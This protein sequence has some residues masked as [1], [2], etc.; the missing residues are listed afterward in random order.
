MKVI[1]ITGISFRE[2]YDCITLFVHLQYV[3]HKRKCGLFFE[4][5]KSLLVCPWGM[6]CNIDIIK[7]RR[8]ISSTIVLPTPL[9]ADRSVS[10]R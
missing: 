9:S 4:I 3:I 10:Y 2:I 7:P 6:K 5:W 1:R 8:S